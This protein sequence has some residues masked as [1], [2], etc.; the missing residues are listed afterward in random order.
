V[1]SDDPEVTEMVVPVNL[2]IA[3]PAGQ[4]VSVPGLFASQVT[5]CRLRDER[6]IDTVEEAFSL[7]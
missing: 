6:T 1:A 4:A 2:Q 3:K 7:R 5:V